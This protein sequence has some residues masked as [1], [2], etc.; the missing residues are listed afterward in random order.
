MIPENGRDSIKPREI[1]F[2]TFEISCAVASPGRPGFCFGSDDGR[3]LFMSLDG[4]GGIGPFAISP[5]KEA[6]N[7]IAFAG[8]L[9]AVST[10]NDVTFLRTP[11]ADEVHPARTVFDGGSHGVASTPAGCIIAPMGRRGILV[12]DPRPET[13]QRVR[14]LKPADEALYVYKIVSLASPDRGTI[15]A[16]AGRR[17]GFATMPLSGSGLESHGKKLRPVGV[18]FVDVA[19]LDVDGFPFAVAALGIDCS[20]HFIADLLGDQMTTTLRLSSTAER[21]YRILST[22]GHV[23]L[24]TDKRL[25]AFKDLA[26]RFLRG[27]A[28]SDPNARFLELEA[29][30]ASLGPDRSLLVVMPDGVREIKL[31]SMVAEAGVSTGGLRNGWRADS[32]SKM[33]P[34]RE[35]DELWKQP[36]E[37]EL[38]QVV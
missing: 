32:S 36:E 3:V 2:E 16:C 5:S 37:L 17:G 9:M 38:T 35:I 15:V 31:D 26:I 18:D 7:G 25:Y 1:S 6:V 22:E 4:V 29:V 8:N 13:P 33:I 20:I 24:L 10:R 19:A 28:I 30:D 23:F 11:E 21:A 12:M 14:I 34:T 27:E